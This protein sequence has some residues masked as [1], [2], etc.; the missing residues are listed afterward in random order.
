MLCETNGAVIKISA[1][2]K[3]KAD[4]KFWVKQRCCYAW[5]PRLDQQGGEK[6][7]RVFRG[8]TSSS[9]WIQRR[10][11]ISIAYQEKFES[12]LFFFVC[13]DMS[14]LAAES[15]I[16]RTC[17][18]YKPMSLIGAHT[19]NYRLVRASFICC[20]SCCDGARLPRN[21]RSQQNPAV[22]TRKGSELAPQA[23]GSLSSFVLK[24]RRRVRSNIQPA[25]LGYNSLRMRW[26]FRI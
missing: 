24:W 20:H 7:S 1:N 11:K 3:K 21:Y 15:K 6:R 13:L 17:A 12:G 5:G 2:C 19:Q 23:I 4:L 16:F 10:T 26:S 25:Q 8:L 9:H 22:I 18:L 14:A